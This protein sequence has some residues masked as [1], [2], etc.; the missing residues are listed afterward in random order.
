MDIACGMAVLR[1]ADVFAQGILAAPHGE[2][3]K[4]WKYHLLCQIS[5]MFLSFFFFFVLFNLVWEL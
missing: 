2:C 5:S 4:N 3:L 1:G